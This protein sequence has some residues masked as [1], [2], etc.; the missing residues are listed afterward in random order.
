MFF[1]PPQNKGRCVFVSVCLSVYKIL[2]SVEV[3]AGYKSHLVTALVI[4]RNDGKHVN[5]WKACSK[6]WWSGKS[7]APFL[8][9]ASLTVAPIPIHQ[10]SRNY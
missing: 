9:K 2:D 7:I 4:S 5:E 3:L 8:S 1:I 10:L 6:I